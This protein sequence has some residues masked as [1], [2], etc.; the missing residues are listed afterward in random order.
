MLLGVAMVGMAST[1]A[2]A[3]TSDGQA[4]VATFLGYEIG[5]ERRYVIAPDDAMRDGE[6]ATWSVRLNR[7]ETDKGRSIGVFGLTHVES[8]WGLNP[9]RVLVEWNYVGEARINEFGF[10][11]A[12]R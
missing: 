6:S 4:V 11:E 3:R 10:P 9:R 1:N 12:V 7:V 5:E 2:A 8:R